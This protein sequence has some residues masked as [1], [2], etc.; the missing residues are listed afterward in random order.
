MSVTVKNNQTTTVDIP[1]EGLVFDAGES[2][3]VAEITLPLAEAIQSGDID[4]VS[5][6]VEVVLAV[7]TPGQTE[8][9][10]P[11]AWPGPDFISLAVGG[12]VQAYG[13]D[14]EVD[15]ETNVLTWLDSNVTLAVTDVLVLSG[16]WAS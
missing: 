11:F 5:Q 14:W 2:K 16:R 12:L 13:E 15:A 6:D 1:G 10:L 9:D 3:T 7:E 8:F 4:V